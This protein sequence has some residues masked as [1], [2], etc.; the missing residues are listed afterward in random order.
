[1]KILLTLTAP[2]ALAGL[3]V[4]QQ[5]LIPMQA[6]SDLAEFTG[7]A[8]ATSGLSVRASSGCDDFNRTT[9]LGADW[10]VVYGVPGIINDEYASLQWGNSQYLPASMNYDAAIISFDLPDNPMATRYGAAISGLGAADNLYVKVQ[11]NGAGLG[12][13][14]TVGFY[15]GNGSNTSGTTGWG[16]FFGLTVPVTGGIVTVYIDP[17]SGGDILNVDIDEDRDGVVDQTLIAPGSILAGF[18]AGT[19]G[20][21]VGV[22]CYGDGVIGD[23]DDF[24]LNGGCAPQG[25]ALALTCANGLATA[26]FSGFTPGS[27]IAVVYG[28][29]VPYVHA[30][31]PCTGTALDLTPM[32][33]PVV[34][35]ADANGNAQ[36]VQG[37]GAAVC[38]SGILVQGVE[39]AI[40][41]PSNSAAL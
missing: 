17:A 26:D 37:V 34:I 15:T 12:V 40:C 28:P 38:G 7:A 32:T 20:D 18:P 41:A 22:G 16:G 3:A 30:G 13:Y 2:I 8:P 35:G 25:P 11:S 31:S 4:A 5:N 33:G 36:I 24:E 27:A 9:G 1:M 6:G 10:A 14:N 39:I 21:G 19:L 29:P 23:I